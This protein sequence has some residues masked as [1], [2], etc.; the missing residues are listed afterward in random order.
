MFGKSDKNKKYKAG[1]V[2]TLIGSGTE[3]RG[4]VLFSGGLHTDGHIKGKVLSNLGEQATLSI[5]EVGSID[6]DVSVPDITVNGSVTGNVYS[7]E[8]M[9]LASRARVNG[10]VY[11]NRLEIQPG[12]E[13]NGQMVHDPTGDAAPDSLRETAGD[14]APTEL[15]E[16]KRVQTVTRS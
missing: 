16:V 8:R 13:V 4:D 12:A 14:S 10:N 6:G 7:S 11:Y 3:I 1:V 9:V 5:S 15:R 2:D